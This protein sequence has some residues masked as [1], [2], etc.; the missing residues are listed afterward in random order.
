MARVVPGPSVQPS[1]GGSGVFPSRGLWRDTL[2]G[3][4]TR[5][6]EV[7][8]GGWRWDTLA[9][10]GTRWLA[11]AAEDAQFHGFPSLTPNAIQSLG[12]WVCSIACGQ[13]FLSCSHPI[14]E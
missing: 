9:G 11:V 10:G 4:G 14:G 6:L 13:R 5:W 1:R 2:A 12:P 3:G 8:H 7:G